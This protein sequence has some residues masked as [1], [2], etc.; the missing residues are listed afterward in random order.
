[1]NGITGSAL[2]LCAGC[3]LCSV[4]GMLTPDGKGKKVFN[5]VLGLFLICSV[6]LP[7][8]NAV[9]DFNNLLQSSSKNSALMQS[10]DE[11]LKD[12]II[13]QTADNLV[14]ALNELYKGEG[15]T[16]KNITV[17]VTKESDDGIKADEIC[18]YIKK[19]DE[20]NKNKYIK[21]TYDNTKIKPKIIT[22]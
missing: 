6:I 22:E 14:L 2:S 19:E 7:I 3:I 21:L 12:S 18:I 9:R 4:I 10:A 15:L 20:V 16:P 8:K 11:K 5:L 17:A 1:M 13:K